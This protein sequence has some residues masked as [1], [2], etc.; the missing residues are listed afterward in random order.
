MIPR[1]VQVGGAG[2]DIVVVGLKPLVIVGRD[3][4]AEDVDRLGLALEP[5]VSSS[6]MNASG[7]WR[8]SIAP[9]IVS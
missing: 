1:V 9:A 2:L 7:R 8:S 3:P 5:T 6:E 4:V